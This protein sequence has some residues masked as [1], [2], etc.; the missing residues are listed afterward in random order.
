MFPSPLA[1]TLL[2]AALPCLLCCGLALADEV[3]LKNGDRLTGAIV[4]ADSKTLTLKT[5][6]AGTITIAAAA[7]AHVAA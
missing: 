5:D 6:Y 7:I 2:R 1:F 3:R 4:K